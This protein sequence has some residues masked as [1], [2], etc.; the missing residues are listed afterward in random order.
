MLPQLSDIKIRRKQLGITQSELAQ[1]TSVSQSLIAKIE[2]GKVIPSY[3]NAKKLFDYLDSVEE[4]NQ[5]IAGDLMNDKVVFIEADSPVKKAVRLMEQ[6]SVSQLP[7]VRNG[8]VVGTI[9]EKDV[10]G[11]IGKSKNPDQIASSRVEDIMTDALPQISKTSPFKIVSAL[12]QHHNAVLVME[13]G[14]I[15]GILSKSDL[16][17]LILNQKRK[18]IQF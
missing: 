6:Y 14:K 2:S 12:M 15:I 7:V 9:D 1:Q 13:K 4:K 3:E 5:M 8:H 10:L 17:K 18:I 16:L 11:Q